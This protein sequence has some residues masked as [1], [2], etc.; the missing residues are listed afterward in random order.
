[1]QEFERS[2]AFLYLNEVKRRFQS[3]YGSRAETAIAYSMNNEFAPTMASEM[4]CPYSNPFFNKEIMHVFFS[5]FNLC[6][7]SKNCMFL[8]FQRHYSESREI[9]TISRVHG[10]LEEVKNIMVKNIGKSLSISCFPVFGL[11][12]QHS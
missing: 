9:D 1:M 6:I 11:V 3:L 10:E 12:S 5:P 7:E 8:L 2:R 4:V